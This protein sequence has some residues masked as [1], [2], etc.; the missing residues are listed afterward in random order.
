MSNSKEVQEVP[1]EIEVIVPAINVYPYTC[2][3]CDLKGKS[4]N[5]WNRHIK[6]HCQCKICEKIFTAIVILKS[7]KSSIPSSEKNLIAQN[8][9]KNLN[10][11]VI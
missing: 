5:M 4:D 2:S 7:V 10:L 11:E 9:R 3:F 6:S 1:E 8:V